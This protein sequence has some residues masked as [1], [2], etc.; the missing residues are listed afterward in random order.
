MEGAAQA[1]KNVQMFNTESYFPCL[2]EFCFFLP[3]VLNIVSNEGPEDAVAALAQTDHHTA[4]LLPREIP[5]ARV[6]QQGV[7]KNH[8]MG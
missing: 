7:R 5:G 2:E 1:I 6:L 8:P 3:L 4:C